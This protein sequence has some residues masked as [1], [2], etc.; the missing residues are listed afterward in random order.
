MTGAVT[1]EM[2]EVTCK[3]CLKRITR[4]NLRPK[5][6]FPAIPTFDVVAEGWFSCGPGRKRGCHLVFRCPVCG[7]KISHGGWF[8]DL[9]A[10]DGHRASHCNCWPKGYYIREVQGEAVK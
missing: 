1:R 5:S 6:E 3:V 9:G 2:S 10:A 7:Q 8:K 4:H